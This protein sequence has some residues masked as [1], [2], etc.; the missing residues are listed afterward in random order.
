MKLN[1]S[2]A[3]AIRKDYLY[4]VGHQVIT[5]DGIKEI[6]VLPIIND[7]FGTFPYL[8]TLAS[9]KEDFLKPYM[10]KEMSLVIFYTDDSYYYFF[11]YVKDTQISI[12]WSKYVK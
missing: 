7:D 11:Q 9:N 6:V 3:N 2:Q 1:Y 5:P 12:D 8:Y 10:D 4:L